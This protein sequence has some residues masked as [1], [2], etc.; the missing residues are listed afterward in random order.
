MSRQPYLTGDQIRALT[1]KYHVQASLAV[2]L[3]RVAR[4]V[5]ARDQLLRHCNQQEMIYEQVVDNLASTE[6]EKVQREMASLRATI[7]ALRK[8]VYDLEA[9]DK[10]NLYDSL[11]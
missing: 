2:D 3:L 5:D 11:Y 1:Q 6:R 4:E 7:A 8:E 9:W 10:G